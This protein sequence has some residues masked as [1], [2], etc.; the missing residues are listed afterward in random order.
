[1]KQLRQMQEGLDE[2]EITEQ[3]H[4]IHALYNYFLEP[5]QEPVGDYY[6]VGAGFPETPHFQMDLAQM[7]RSYRLRIAEVD[8]AIGR[9]R[10]TLEEL[11]QWEDT[12]LVVTA[13]H[14]EAFF[15]HGYERHDYVPYNEVIKVPLIISYPALL[16]QRTLHEAR[17]LA[18]HLDLMPTI[19]SLAGLELP[20]GADGVDL[21]PTL[22]GE[23][24]LDAERAIYPV[25]MRTANLPQYPLKRVMLQGDLKF[26][27]GSKHYG[28]EQ[29]LLFQLSVDPEETSSLHMGR[30]IRF[31]RM[32][33]KTQA[34]RMGLVPVPPSMPVD[35]EE[36]IDEET[37][38]ELQA[39]GYFDGEEDED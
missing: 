21:S 3:A 10:A 14:G 38:Q 5:G 7:K 16:K 25:I 20:R 30:R 27:E 15:E 1:L 26:I 19:L 35:A 2:P 18:W 11:G 8:A 22:R 32:Q 31:D 12:L 36:T 33:A 17:G 39:L 13:D 6:R 34:Y 24:P 9:I 4:R 37:L 23:A 29:G 28:A